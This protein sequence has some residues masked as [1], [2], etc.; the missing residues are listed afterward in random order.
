[1]KTPLNNTLVIKYHNSTYFYFI[2]HYVLPQGIC[3]LHEDLFF[4]ILKVWTH[5][6]KLSALD[7]FVETNTTISLGLKN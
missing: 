5:H 4:H 3:F 1:M 2:L 7:I 6:F